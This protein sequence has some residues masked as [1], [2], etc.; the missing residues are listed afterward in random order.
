MASPVPPAE[1][2]ATPRNERRE[3]L[4]GLTTGLVQTVRDALAASDG[5]RIRTLVAPLH[6]AD[7]ADL[8]ERFRPDE[9]Q[10]LAAVAADVL[11]GD[12][13]ANVE[14]DIREELIAEIGAARVAEAIT[15]MD[16]DDAVAVIEDL[17]EPQQKE[18]LDAIP[19][20]ERLRV[21]ESL[22]YPE[23]SAGRLMQ[24]EFVA[25]PAFWTVGRTIDH[26]RET[27]DLPDE[28]YEI[29]VLDAHRHP[30]G[31]VPLHT[32][33]RTR[34]PMLLR[35][36]M[37]ADLKTIPAETD[38]EEVGH[39]F[40]QYDLV[41]A[42]G[43]GRR[44]AADRRHHHRRCGGR[45]P[46]GGGRRHPAPQRRPGG[47]YLSRRPCARPGAASPGF[48]STSPRRFSPPT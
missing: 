46:G 35:D 44:R 8:I 10:R 48:W 40:E 31:R 6:D 32:L 15:D 39:V 47:G 21:E 4:Y 11:S 45:D 41:S 2:G 34:R 30:V 25:L 9:R 18:I 20:D 12:V 14:D 27:A 42:P 37:T 38:Q 24:R 23:E 29:Y 13:L 28:F 33:M 16:T 19:G 17:D 36:V 5:D 43:G 22:T 3:G 7:T 1:T 26:M